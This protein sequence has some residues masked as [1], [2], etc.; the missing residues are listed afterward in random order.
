MAGK[1]SQSWL[2]TTAAVLGVGLGLLTVV[3]VVMAVMA[4]RGEPVSFTLA[5]G[6]VLGT[7]PEQATL[8]PGVALSPDAPVPVRLADPTTAQSAWGVLLWLPTSVVGG[9]A[10]TLVLLAVLRARRGDPFS[11]GVVAIMRTLGLVLLVG[12]PLVQLLTGVGSYRLADSVLDHGADFAPAFTLD[13]PLV[14]VCVLALAAVIRHG[15]RL[16]QE[17]D[18]VI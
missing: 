8:V 15:E 3:T 10:L 9:T 2:T 11:G 16:R 5:T 18:A 12:G 14:G 7:Q 6:T 4:T 17:L 1:P 13:G